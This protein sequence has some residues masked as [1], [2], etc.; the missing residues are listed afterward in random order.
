MIRKKFKGVMSIMFVGSFSNVNTILP[1]IQHIL[2]WKLIFS[3][4]A[5]SYRRIY[6]NSVEMRAE[7]RPKYSLGS[8]L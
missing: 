1:Q 7:C 6:I 3:F 2:L 5:V 4:P 8:R